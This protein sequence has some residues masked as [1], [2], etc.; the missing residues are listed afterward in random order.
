VEHPGNHPALIEMELFERVLLILDERDQHALKPRRHRHYLRGLLSCA[1]CGSRLQYTTGRGRHG[2]E[3]HYYVCSKRHK[4]TGCDLPYLPAVAVEERIQDARPQW[5]R[6]DALDGEAVGRQL[7]K[8][9]VG[10]RD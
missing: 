7:H 1:R 8:L 3:F 5:V 6:L 2:D 9:L 4:G 10:D